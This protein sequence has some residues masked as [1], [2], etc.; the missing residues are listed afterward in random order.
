[1][2]F[3][4]KRDG[5]FTSGR[6]KAKTT[7]GMVIYHSIGDVRSGQTQL[8]QNQ[9]IEIPP[10]PPSGLDGCN[11]IDITY[12]LVVSIM[13]KCNKLN[14]FHV[15]SGFSRYIFVIFQI[16]VTPKDGRPI[17]LTFELTVGTVPAHQTVFDESNG[18]SSPTQTAL[19]PSAPP[20]NTL[21][22]P[23]PYEDMRK[24]FAIFLAVEKLSK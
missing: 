18:E 6:M 10:I 1:M 7:S 24:F 20:I 5:F 17:H 15:G 21:E 19:D 4:G 11:I 13:N 3:Y 12:S 9:S 16:Q 14:M 8:W 22:G 2:T 23:P